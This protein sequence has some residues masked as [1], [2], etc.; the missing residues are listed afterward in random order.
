MDI[1]RAIATTI[2]DRIMTAGQISRE[3][4]CSVTYVSE[5]LRRMHARRQVTLLGSAT[6]GAVV[7]RKWTVG[8]VETREEPAPAAPVAPEAVIP[9]STRQR[10]PA[11][12]LEAMMAQL[13]GGQ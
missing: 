4:G 5:T 11:S 2:T 10:A 7:R 9:V 13:G 1:E 12:G 3:L 6:T 8:P